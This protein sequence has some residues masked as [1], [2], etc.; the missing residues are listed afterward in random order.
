MSRWF[1]FGT[2]KEVE[3]QTTRALP[4]SWY[5][6]SAMYELERRAIFSK[7]WIAVSHQARFAEV[8]DFLRITQAGFTFFL[9]KDRQ[10]EIRAHHNVCRHRAFPLVEQDA[11]R[12]NILSCKYHGWSYGLDGKLAKAPKYQEVPSF[13][14]STNNLY[15]IHVHI[16]KLGFIWVNMDASATPTVAWDDDFAGVDTQPRLQPF[17]MAAYHFDHQWEMIGDYNWKTLADNYN[18][19]YHCPT[20]HPALN[21]LTDLSKYWVETSGGHIQHFNV[22][23]PDKDGMGIYSTF[24]YPN[25]SIT[26][27][28]TFFYIMRCIPI[29]ASQTKMEYEV[30]RSN[31]ASDEDFNEISNCFKQILK[32]DKDLCNAAQKNL[33]AGIFVNGE[34]HP[35]VEKGPLFFQETTR[36]LVMEH[37]QQ[38]GHEG[39]EVWPAAPKNGQSG[40][41]QDDIDFCNKLEACAGSDS[42]MW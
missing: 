16:D 19:C 25:A 4:A 22:D 1:S 32:E 5:R 38:E 7:K 30:Y 40:N 2:T 3:P 28:P 41:G 6:S 35:R 9:I 23:K 42:S 29:S 14:K 12:V 8:G 24:Y 20:G 27:S 31:S 13:D 26:I 10:G 37:H 39:H 21:A 11:G 33:N 18:E 34:L 17:D 15:P 36:K